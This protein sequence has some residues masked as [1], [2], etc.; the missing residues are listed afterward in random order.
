MTL[1][2]TKSLPTEVGHYWIKGPPVGR[3]IVRV[4]E[5]YVSKQLYF[6]RDGWFPRTL[7]NCPGGCEWAGPLPEPDDE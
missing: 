4:Y 6:Y 5:P 2:W 1:K 7:D 3:T